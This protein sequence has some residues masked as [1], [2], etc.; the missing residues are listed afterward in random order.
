M[1][2]L[3]HKCTCWENGIKLGWSIDL[4]D[5]IN[6]KYKRLLNEWSDIINPL[7]SVRSSEGATLGNADHCKCSSGLRWELCNCK[8][9]LVRV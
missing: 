4:E 5:D 7:M 9:V 2:S 6:L 8:V 3:E 1:S